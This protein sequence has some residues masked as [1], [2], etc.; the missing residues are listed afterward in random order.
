MYG[1]L[2]RSLLAAVLVVSAAIASGCAHQM[3]KPTTTLD[4][5]RIDDDLTLRRMVVRNGTPTRTV[6][7][8]HGFPETI[9][10]WQNIAPALGDGL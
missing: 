2:L 1:S 10:A 8:L 4:E 6:L 3:T 9:Y 5:I 7:F